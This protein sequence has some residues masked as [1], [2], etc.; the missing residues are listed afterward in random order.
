[1][2][3]LRKYHV[4]GEAKLCPQTTLLSCS[5]PTIFRVNFGSSNKISS[6]QRARYSQHSSCMYVMVKGQFAKD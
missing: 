3:M 4:A 5:R 2:T 6:L 1:M